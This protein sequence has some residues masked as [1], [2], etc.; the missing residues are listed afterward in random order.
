PAI[1]L[2]Y[3]QPMDAGINLDEATRI[4]IGLVRR[5]T[6]GSAI[7]HEGPE[8]ELTYSMVGGQEDFAGADDLL[9]T[10]RW[11]GTAIAAGLSTLDAAAEMVAVQPSI[12]AALPHLCFA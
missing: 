6:G 8:L 2:G 3:G 9:S 12:T 4:G 5:L 10:Y 11:I 1:S 7:L